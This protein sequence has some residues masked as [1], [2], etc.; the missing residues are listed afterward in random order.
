MIKSLLE[1]DE[2]ESNE[3]IENAAEKKATENDALKLP[4]QNA[5]K[6]SE[7]I[8]LVESL[9]EKNI[10]TPENMNNS[11]QSEDFQKEEF[12]KRFA[13]IESM[14]ESE[15]EKY[16]DGEDFLKDDEPYL[17][18]EQTPQ[19]ENPYA[20]VEPITATSQTVYDEV[21]PVENANVSQNQEINPPVVK[22]KEYAPESQSES[23]RQSGMAWSAAIALFGSV[24]FFMIIGWFADLLLGTAPWS[25][26]GGIVIGGIMGFVQFFRISSR[27]FKPQI[28]EFER[29]SFRGNENTEVVEIIETVSTENKIT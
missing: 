4:F 27:I 29:T 21:V 19:T 17:Y 3:K 6:K 10:Q 13:G 16:L 15:I 20:G 12:E 25:L 22:P 24:V 23:I 26:V 1:P 2:P 18:S 9:P 11:V 8:P 14:S 28:S 7:Q 5:L